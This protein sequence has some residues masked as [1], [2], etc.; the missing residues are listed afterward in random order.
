MGHKIFIRHTYIYKCSNKKCEG[1][2]KI[3]E[4][5]DLDKL[6]CPHCGKKDSVEYVRDDQRDKYQRRWE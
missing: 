4:A 3:N 5:N 6:T 2:W 1:E